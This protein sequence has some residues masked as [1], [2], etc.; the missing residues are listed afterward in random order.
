MF[1]VHLNVSHR[2]RD[3]TSTP[4]RYT[5]HAKS[6]CSALLFYRARPSSPNP[7]HPQ[8]KETVRGQ[9][10]SP[11]QPNLPKP[12]SPSHHPSPPPRGAPPSNAPCG[13]SPTKSPPAPSAP[14][15]SSQR[16]SSPHHAQSATRSAATPLRQRY[17]GE[18][19]HITT[20][21]LSLF[22]PPPHFRLLLPPPVSVPILTPPHQPPCNSHQQNPRRFQRQ[23]RTARRRGHYADGKADAASQG[24]RE[25]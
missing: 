4:K 9:K 21:T 15:P 20:S 2:I 7:R 10:P 11:K 23:D 16:T 12:P 14:M 3:K 13:A 1:P 24:G 5:S 6:P 18:F 25:I 19:I 22:S 8:T 17:P